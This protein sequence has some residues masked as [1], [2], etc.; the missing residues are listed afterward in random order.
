MAGSLG[1]QDRFTVT[2][3]TVSFLLLVASLTAGLNHYSLWGDE[4]ASSFF[5][6]SD[7]ADLVSRLLRSRQSEGSQPLYYLCLWIWTQAFGQSAIALRLPSLLCSVA[8]V[9]ILWRTLRGLELESALAWVGAATLLAL[10]VI[11]WYSLEARAYVFT[12]L[13]A[14]IY[15]EETTTVLID[16]SRSLTRLAAL[17]LVVSLAF[18]VGGVAALLALGAVVVQRMMQP[19]IP[20]ARHRSPVRW[21]WTGLTGAFVLMTVLIVF[22]S[23][24]RAETVVVPQPRPAQASLAYDLYELTLGRTIGLSVTEIR[25]A[26]PATLHGLAVSGGTDSLLI[27][28]VLGTALEVVL[29]CGLAALRPRRDETAIL[30]AAPWVVT[31]SAFGVYAALHG[32]PIL[33]RHLLFALPA[34]YLLAVVGLAHADTRRRRVATVLVWLTGAIAMAGFAFGARYAKDDYRGVARV[35]HSC[36][37]TPANTFVVDAVPLWGFDYYGVSARTGTVQEG[38][39]FVQATG[40]EPRVLVVNL[41]RLNEGPVQQYSFPTGAPKLTATALTVLAGGG[42]HRLD[43]PGLIVLADTSL[44]RCGHR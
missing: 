2:V 9:L 25:D 31:T 33:G 6:R 26:R 37:I 42:L 21:L 43:L 8:T 38:I 20:S 39:Q 17:A 15:L 36:G 4:A 27:A 34:L 16:R 23:A 28:V 11:I 12:M 29:L 18:S 22:W 7:F 35:L 10:P 19:A 30:A 5:V 24:V 32:L 14:T 41:G 1:R 13:C 44:R 40:V 3:V